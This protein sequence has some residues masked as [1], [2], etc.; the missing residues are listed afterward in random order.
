[1]PTL[2][3]ELAG[4]SI[5]ASFFLLAIAFVFNAIMLWLNWKQAKVKDIMPKLIGEVK[6]IRE[7]LKKYMEMKK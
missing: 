3:P 6:G 7:D 5:I 2:T 1:M 4:T